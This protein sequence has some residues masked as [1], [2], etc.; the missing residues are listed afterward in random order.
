MQNKDR[1]LSWDPEGIFK[2]AA[3]VS[4][5]ADETDTQE[6][7][8]PLD[9]NFLLKHPIVPLKGEHADGINTTDSKAYNRAKFEKSLREKYMPINLNHPGV[10]ILHIDPPI[11]QVDGFWT[12]DQCKEMIDAAR[13]TGEIAAA[14]KFF[15]S[16]LNN[17]LKDNHSHIPVLMQG[18]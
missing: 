10:R 9:P 8:A 15:F 12:V 16:C 7:H 1:N 5:F 18:E 11:F 4:L 17:C 6:A 13:S 3:A 14:W 2:D